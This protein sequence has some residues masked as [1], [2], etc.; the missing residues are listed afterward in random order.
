MLVLSQYTAKQGRET[1]GNLE[2]NVFLFPGLW[3]LQCLRV[4]KKLLVFMHAKM[5]VHNC[6]EV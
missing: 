5:I 4:L 1:R 6:F 2:P 3:R